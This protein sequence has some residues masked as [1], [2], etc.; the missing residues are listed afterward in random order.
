[1]AEDNEGMRPEGGLTRN[2][3][4]EEVWTLKAKGAVDEAD[5]EDVERLGSASA[6]AGFCFWLVVGTDLSGK[7]GRHQRAF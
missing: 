7:E 1:M 4:G 5:E 3:F 6:Q 2:L